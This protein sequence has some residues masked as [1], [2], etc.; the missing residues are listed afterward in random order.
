M[1]MVR[2]RFSCRSIVIADGKQVSKL[3]RK[4]G[5]RFGKP[6]LVVAFRARSNAS[7]LIMCYCGVE[8]KRCLRTEFSILR[9]SKHGTLAA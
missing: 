8:V 9:C 6:F 7:N 5:L 4:N 2:R 3:E 1:G